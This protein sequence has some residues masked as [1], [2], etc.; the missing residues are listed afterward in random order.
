MKSATTS[1]VNVAGP[2]SSRPSTTWSAAWSGNTSAV[3]HASM[4]ALGLVFIFDVI[5]QPG[6]IT[7]DFRSYYLAGWAARL[8]STIYD[9]AVLREIGAILEVETPINP[10]LYPPPLAFAASALARLSPSA[11]QVV[12]WAVGLGLIAPAV[13]QLTIQMA[14]LND[15]NDA[16]GARASV[17]LPELSLMFM[18]GG[19]LLW[20]F[21]IRSNMWWGQ[22]NP[23]VVAVILFAT[24][25]HLRKNGAACGAL[26]AVAALIKMTPA[27]LLL[28]F[29]ADRS[30]RRSVLAGFAGALILGFVATLPLG[31]F[32][33]WL[34]FIDQVP[35]MSHGSHI[36]GL[37]PAS[38]P[39]NYS[40]AGFFARLAGDGTLVTRVL[41]YAAVLT[42]LAP[43]L[44]QLWRARR[45]P[46]GRAL[47]LMPLS[48]VMMIGSPLAYAHYVLYLLPGALFQLAFAV[49]S[50]QVKYVG[51]LA[52]LFAIVS[53][54][55]PA[56]YYRF[57]YG[58][59]GDLLLTSL[60]LYALLVL[61]L[62]GMRLAAST[63]AATAAE[64]T[65][66]DSERQLQGGL[67]TS[68]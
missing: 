33:A 34:A 22:V 25:A 52:A 7:E 19:F 59:M 18:L 50:G 23:I 31:G 41:T 68:P 62:V 55:F 10:Y 48:I 6:R 30:L 13:T 1:D 38:S 29:C 17:A 35:R 11:A 67:V 56:F 5:T 58:P 43:I 37:F 36:P 57:H 16:N 9:P 64:Q 65:P 14:R 54:D 21:N 3:L 45:D 53:T 4:I 40:F 39:A 27:L 66:A 15:G 2:R 8:G 47:L 61:Y 42:L 51:L 63:I 32:S 28:Y 49:R 26:L 24:R 46:R 44:V 60:N 20:M 12:W